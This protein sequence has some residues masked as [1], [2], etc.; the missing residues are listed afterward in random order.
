MNRLNLPAMFAVALGFW[1]GG[2]LMLWQMVWAANGRAHPSWAQWG[3]VLTWPGR[4]GPP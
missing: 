4:V 2:V 1:L 3:R